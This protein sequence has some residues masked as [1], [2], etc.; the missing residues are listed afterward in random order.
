MIKKIE[1]IADALS[2]FEIAANKHAEATEQGNYKE[3][4]K[5]YGRIIKA[6]AYLKEQNAINE[7]TTR[8]VHPSIGVRLWASTYLLPI[9][10]A[11][12]MKCLNDIVRGKSV[13]ALTAETTMSEW[14]KGNLNL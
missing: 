3:A 12:S 4:N 5:S 8:I 11:D 7:L 9:K 2:E 13:H 10:E 1:T 14:K 6:I